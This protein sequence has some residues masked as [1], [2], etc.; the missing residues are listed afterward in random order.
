MGSNVN[1]SA[2]RDWDHPRAI[3]SAAAVAVSVPLNL[4][5]V[6]RIFTR[7]RALLDNAIGV[8]NKARV[9]QDCCGWSA[10]QPRSAKAALQIPAVMA[11]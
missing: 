2:G 8:R 9:V 1:E 6:I 7:C 3:A 11:F 5:G 10:T 4:S